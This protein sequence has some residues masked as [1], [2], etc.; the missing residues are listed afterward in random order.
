MPEIDTYR[1]IQHDPQQLIVDHMVLV[2][3]V[4]CHLKARLPDSYQLD[5]LVQAGTLGL[6]EAARA[7]DRSLGVVFEAFARQRI[8]GA[9]LD[10]VRRNSALPR[11]A[12][13]NLRAHNEAEHRIANKL[14]RKPTHAELAD[15]L[16]MELAQ[17]E[18]QRQHAHQF[19]ITPL[20]VSSTEETDE[21]IDASTPE[22]T[23][24][25]E[26][27]LKSLADAIHDL[28]ERDQLILALYYSEELNLKEI[29]AIVGVSESRIS[30]ILSATAAKL[31]TR[32]NKGKIDSS[33]AGPP[34]SPSG[35]Q[36]GGSS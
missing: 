7:F 22:D 10:D 14:G 3:Q 27:E 2:R 12:V 36:T 13:A 11:S 20:D 15:E 23:L 6:I 5:D 19:Q 33:R 28:G 31:R 18:R 24:A 26:Q 35:H 1:R 16:G 9:I 17:F 21:I 25:S 32:L 29:G 8:R 34:G 4:A 30:Q